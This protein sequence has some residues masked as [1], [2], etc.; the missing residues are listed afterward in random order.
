MPFTPFHFGPSCCVSLP[1]KKYIDFP[2]FVLANVII[3]FEPL[4]VILFGLNYPLH[5]YCHT[6]LIGSLIGILWASI[7]YSGKSILQRL[8]KL[9]HLSYDTNFGKMLISAILGIWFHVLFDAPLYSDIQ[10]FYPFKA[11][12]MYGILTSSTVYLICA[13]SF[14][15]ALILYIIGVVSFTKKNKKIY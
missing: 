7:A 6:F 9:L 2:V 8:M 10:P 4:V 3:D 13:I 12:P 11:N 1:L 15:P 5:G 14:I